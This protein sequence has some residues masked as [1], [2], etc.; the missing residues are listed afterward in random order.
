M[1]RFQSSSETHN[2]NMFFFS[3]GDVILEVD[4]KNVEE[5]EHK[6]IVSMIHSATLSVRCVNFF[7]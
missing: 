1:K 6:A 7:W 2:F 4:G 5:E 3:T